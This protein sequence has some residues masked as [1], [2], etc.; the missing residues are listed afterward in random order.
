[1]QEKI[2]L[3][4][5]PT[6]KEYIKYVYNYFYSISR[7]QVI[8]VMSAIFFIVN[9]I[10]LHD[11][12]IFAASLFLCSFIGIVPYLKA[13]KAYK[14][15]K[16]G[17]TENYIALSEEGVYISSS[18]GELNM[19]WDEVYKVVEYGDSYALYVSVGSASLIPKSRFKNKG[20]I[21]KF[22]R[23]LESNMDK[24]KLYIGTRKKV[25]MIVG[26]IATTFIIAVLSLIA[27]IFV[28][29]KTAFR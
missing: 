2:E 24:T 7:A 15:N 25:S 9:V 18:W 3:K 14:V 20:E 27:L 10:Y 6:K 8:A 26:F 5:K 19:K 16:I 22:I 12:F 4:I 21:N 23:L 13:K 11:K 28:I 29:S 17:E 1:M